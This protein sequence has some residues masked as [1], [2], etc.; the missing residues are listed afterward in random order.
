M[1]VVTSRER[2][3][4]HDDDV[5]MEEEDEYPLS[6]LSVNNNIRLQSQQQKWQAGRDT[7][8]KNSA[9]SF[10]STH[11]GKSIEVHNKNQSFI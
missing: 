10:P 6:H 4:A 1:M 11:T 5:D 8:G 9:Q 3:N 2:G 7:R